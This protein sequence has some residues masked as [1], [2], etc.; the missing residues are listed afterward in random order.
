LFWNTITVGSDDAMTNPQDTAS[1]TKAVAR[2][3]KRATLASRSDE[4]ILNL[5]F[6]DLDLTIKG[7]PLEKRIRQLRAELEQAG[8]VFR[9]HLWLSNEWFTPDG[10]T[11][12]AVPF[13]LAHQRLAQLELNQMLEVEGG[14]A[15]WCMRI[16]RHEAGHAIDNAYR[17]RR[18]KMRQK[19]FKRSSRPYPDYYTPRPYSKSFVIYLD[20]WYAQ[21][22][23]DED[24][25]ET[26]AVWLDPRS[27]WRKRYAGWRALHKLEYMDFLMKELADKPPVVE[28]KVR[29]DPLHRMR[30]KLRVHYREKRDLHQLNHPSIYDRDLRKL[31]TDAP[32]AAGRPTAAR[33]LSRIRKEV[34]RNVRRWTGVYQYT[35][36]QVFEDI[37]ERC[38]ELG[39]RLAASEEQSK[40]DFIILL[41][42]QTMGYLHSGRH[43]IAL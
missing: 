6:C 37:I 34:R 1:P 16:L 38:R 36:D 26:F 42:V 19:I 8:L 3:L 21:S 27:V 31:F 7:S 35:I 39:L 30:K 29:V 32:E 2:R 4:Q 10:V 23:P 20:G 9:P 15:A 25:A 40:L 14:D 24:F 12:I 17:L 11:G 41:T 22:H 13:Y 28:L 18:R 33:F 43:R 5:R